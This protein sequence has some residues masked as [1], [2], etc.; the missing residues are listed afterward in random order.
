[1]VNLRRTQWLS[2]WPLLAISPLRFF[3]G[4]L[5]TSAVGALWPHMPTAFALGGDIVFVTVTPLIAGGV[6]VMLVQNH[7]R[8]RLDAIA[9]GVAMWASGVATF[10][11][12]MNHGGNVTGWLSG[13]SGIGTGVELSAL[14]S[15]LLGAA[16]LRS[17]AFQ[18]GADGKAERGESGIYGNAEWMSHTESL[19]R[20]AK[21][22]IILG[23]ADRPFPEGSSARFDP[24]KNHTWGRG[25]KGPLLRTD[26][27]KG[28]G[29]MMFFAGS[30]G[31]KTTSMTIPTCLGWPSGLVVLDPSTE[32]E[33]MVQEWRIK[34]GRKVVSFDSE[35]KL[36]S[37]NILDGIDPSKE[38]AIADIQEVVGWMAGA[39]QTG[40]NA[41]FDD[42]ARQV[43]E[44]VLGYIVFNTSLPAEHRN[45]G[46]LR[47]MMMVGPKEM[48]EMFV[49]IEDLGPSFGFGV[50][51]E[52]AARIR[53][54]MQ[55]ERTW[56]SVM[57]SVDLFVDWLKIPGLAYMVS[58]QGA[59][60]IQS[61]SIA[62][63][64]TDVFIN[65]PS[66]VL[67]NNPQAA[68]CLVGA[69]VKA[70]M[71]R[72][73]D[74][75]GRVLFLLDE[76]YQL[77]RL[78]VLA[79]VR[80]LGRK[81]NLNLLLLYQSL[82]Q[83]NET[84]GDDGVSAWF[85]STEIQSFACISHYDTAKFVSERC[86]AYSVVSRSTSESKRHSRQTLKLNDS[87]SLSRSVSQQETE[88]ALIL[89]D[90][91][92]KMREDEQI[93]FVRGARPLWCGRA[94][95]FRRPSWTAIVGENR[96]AANA[97]SP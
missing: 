86:G 80:D 41:S 22:G 59:D 35:K 1:M 84:W 54:L 25:G 78:D 92:M 66:A 27:T 21:G 3:G 30:G 88:R 38:S 17:A 12:F 13:Y 10:V 45:L 11:Y 69:F 23:E 47:R 7:L 75:T 90:E 8:P 26:G 19:E 43:L 37:V 60:V 74:V 55:S 15:F 56:E 79:T 49:A 31:H 40:Q 89:P 65:I 20:F 91:V 64:N 48:K 63:G 77:G 2:I 9:A 76:V 61:A 72:E 33:P 57:M 5:W 51:S 58:G 50:P 87:A 53:G 32:V 71:R 44:C 14:L 82:G 16:F 29:H 28:A 24:K 68:R 46:F 62:D 18:T 81:S 52:L 85:E 67:R 4:L 34:A 39:K 36:G 96:Y 95:Y 93:L 73:G 42:R 70:V 6:A 97:A 83:L 94:L